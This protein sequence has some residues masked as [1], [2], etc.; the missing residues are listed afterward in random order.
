MPIPADAYVALAP[1]VS[2]KVLELPYLYDARTDE[3]YELNDEA[4]AFLRS[5]DG[6]R[7]FD[8][9][10]SAF[11][12]DEET[13]SVLLEENL[14][15]V[16]AA[17]V[18]RAADPATYPAEALARAPSLRY[19]HVLVTRRCNLA[20]RHCFLGAAAAE[21]M[22]VALFAELAREF[23]RIGGLRLMV[24]G[25]EPTEHPRFDELDAAL[26]GLGLRSVLLTNGVAIAD[27]RVDPAALAFTEIQISLDGFESSHDWL[28]GDGA[29]RS[30]TEAARA[31]VAAGKQLS[32]A[33]VVTARNRDEIPGLAAFARELGAHAF[34]VDFPCA[35]GRAASSP[36]LAPPLDAARLLSHA[37]G[38]EYH[39]SPPGHVCG[40]HLASVLPSGRLVKC[41]YYDD[42]SGGD[43]SE[44]LLAAWLRLERL[45]LADLA[46]DCAYLEECRGGCRYRAEVYNGARNAPDP[47]RC[48]LYGVGTKPVASPHEGRERA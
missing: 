6:T 40:A 27:G 30:A 45:R 1:G 7:R 36:E 25:G 32:I 31:V 29:F 21:D 47:V 38:S 46:C 26:A 24:S 14:V 13:L 22:P 39:G 5:L 4:L 16:S 34:R 35:A 9:L 18:P 10:A 48:A 28:R 41:D 8:A 20:C 19:L 12:P 15:L 42:W 43:A 33:T 17:P 37:F 3:L 23:E 44:G 11:H 2:L